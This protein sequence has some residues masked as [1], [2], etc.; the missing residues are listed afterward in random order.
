MLPRQHDSRKGPNPPY[1]APSAGSVAAPRPHPLGSGAAIA[2]LVLA[3]VGAPGVSFVLVLLAV[4]D[5]AIPLGHLMFG[6]P[7]AMQGEPHAVVSSPEVRRVYMG[8]EA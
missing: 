8:I 6:L 3:C 4:L 1:S 2:A 5:S 7:P